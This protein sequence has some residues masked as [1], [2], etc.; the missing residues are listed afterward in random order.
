L[1]VIEVKVGSE[2][3]DDQLK[4][5]RE[6]LSTSGVAKTRL[7]LLTL[8]PPPEELINKPDF[9]LR[10]FEVGECLEHILRER[11]QESADAATFLLRQFLGFLRSKGVT[12]EQVNWQ[13]VEGIESLN[14]L[15]DMLSGGHKKPEA[16]PK[17]RESAA[18]GSSSPG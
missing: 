16:F 7:V 9:P 18:A 8:Y 1:A 12:M 3:R 2:V 14:H 13:L 6:Y 17:P 11:P 10:W 15:M 4:R 5:Y